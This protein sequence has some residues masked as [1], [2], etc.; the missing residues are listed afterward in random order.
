LDVELEVDLYARINKV[1]IAVAI[2]TAR[3]ADLQVV[4]VSPAQTEVVIKSSSDS[5]PAINA[6]N[7]NAEFRDGSTVDVELEANHLWFTPFSPNTTQAQ[8]VQVLGAFLNEN[9]EG[10][11]VVR[12][13]DLVAG[14]VADLKQAQLFFD[15]ELITRN[16]TSHPTVNPTTANPTTSNPTSNPTTRNPT[17]SNPTTA[18]PTTANPTSNPTL[19]PTVDVTPPNIT[20]PGGASAAI[21]VDETTTT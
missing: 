16:P 8:P 1:F 13:C 7:L 5:L 3:R 9:T 15:V 21:V 17:T 2:N 12:V 11:W 4:L 6:I 10:S 14:N 20:C 18:N 19:N